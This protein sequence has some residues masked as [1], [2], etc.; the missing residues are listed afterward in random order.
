[1]E[2]L[3]FAI[4]IQQQQINNSQIAEELLLSVPRCNFGNKWSSRVF[5]G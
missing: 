4:I 5:M 1:M 3:W 2:E